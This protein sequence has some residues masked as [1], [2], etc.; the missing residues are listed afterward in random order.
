MLISIL[1][2]VAGVMAIR[3]GIGWVL[4]G[5]GGVM[6]FFKPKDEDEDGD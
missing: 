5:L 3:F 2:I 1:T 6:T 4:G